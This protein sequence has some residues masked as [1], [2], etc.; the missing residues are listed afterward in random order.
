VQVQEQ[1]QGQ[2]QRQEQRQGQRQRQE[3]RQGQRQRQ[4]QRQ[5][6]RRN[7]GVSPLRFA[8]VEMTWVEGGSRWRGLGWVEMTWVEGDEE[9][10]LLVRE[11]ALL[12]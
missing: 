9:G 6:Q 5:R 11:R 4:E 2:R 7:T 1:R 8:P 3:Q 12:W 10:P